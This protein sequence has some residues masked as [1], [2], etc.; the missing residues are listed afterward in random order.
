[1]LRP[2]GCCTS[3]RTIATVCVDALP[4]SRRSTSA[5][6]A[7]SGRRACCAARARARRR[8]SRRLR[9]RTARPRCR[10]S[11]GPRRRSRGCRALRS[12]RAG[13]R[14][15]DQ[16]CSGDD[17]RAARRPAARASRRRASR[18]P[19]C[20]SGAA[21]GS[22][23]TARSWAESATTRPAANRSSAVARS[24]LAPSVGECRHGPGQCFSGGASHQLPDPA[25]CWRL[26]GLEVGQEAV[27]DGLACLSSVE[28]SPMTP[29]ARSIASEPTSPRSETSAAWRSASICAWALCGDARGLGRGASLASA[30]IFWPSAR[31]VSR[32]LPASAR[33]SASWAVYSSS[34]GL[35]LALSLVGLRDVALDRLGTLIEQ[36]LHARKHELPEEEQDDDEADQRP[37]MSY[38]AGMSGLCAAPPPRR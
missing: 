6:L 32:I 30:T 14:G 3:W 8:R 20:P 1:M 16:R 27:D 17:G 12:R 36:L 22:P 24:A 35:G 18:A 34:S 38:H 31:A 10:R 26:A 13:R 33:A 21:E 28:A 5:A 29:D 23:R 37:T 2:R 4:A 7:R 25:F 11:A 19:P 15:V 9:T